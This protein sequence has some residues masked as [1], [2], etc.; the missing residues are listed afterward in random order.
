[1]AFGQLQLTICLLYGT[2]NLNQTALFSLYSH[3]LT[4]AYASECWLAAVQ[5]S[6]IEEMALPC[7]PLPDGL[8]AEFFEFCLSLAHCGRATD[9]R[10]WQP[11]VTF[12]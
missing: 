3:R 6:R 4:F 7:L 10:Y 9:V 12:H 11:K 2:W 1:M 8:V 5:P